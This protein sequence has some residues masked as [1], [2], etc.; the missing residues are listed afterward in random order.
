MTA[1]QP[2]RVTPDLLRGLGS[3]WRRVADAIDGLDPGAAVASGA[4]WLPGS[5]T[6]D[7]MTGAPV[8][9]AVGMV[10]TAARFEAMAEAAQATADSVESADVSFAEALRRIDGH[11]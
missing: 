10:R 3:G 7:A 8:P 11:R 6:A 4:A 2:L 1:P 9:L 5:A